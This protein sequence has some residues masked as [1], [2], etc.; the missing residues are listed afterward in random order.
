MDDDRRIC[1][2]PVR[3]AGASDISFLDALAAL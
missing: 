2:W 1:Y 3:T